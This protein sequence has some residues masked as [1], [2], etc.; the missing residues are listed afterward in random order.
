M[1]HTLCHLRCQDNMTTCR[2]R[3]S[4]GESGREV[5]YVF[6]L[7]TWFIDLKLVLG[8]LDPFLNN[9]EK[10]ATKK[11][12]MLLN[13]KPKTNLP[14]STEIVLNMH[15]K[16]FWIQCSLW[17]AAKLGCVT[18]EIVHK[19]IPSPQSKLSYIYSIPDN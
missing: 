11:Y 17:L 19:Q 15:K 1:F 16:H 14:T 9:L 12:V 2:H 18:F 6:W 4:L 13:H 8:K 7:K 5:I 10:T 3:T